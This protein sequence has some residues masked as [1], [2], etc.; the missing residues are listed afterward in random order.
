[1]QTM[2]QGTPSQQYQGRRAHS[3]NPRETLD[4]TGD[5]VGG[6]TNGGTEHRTD[7]TDQPFVT[8]AGPWAEAMWTVKNEPDMDDFNGATVTQSPL[9][10]AQ[11]LRHDH[12]R[13]PARQR[14]TLSTNGIAQYLR[15][16]PAPR[17]HR[18]HR[19]TGNEEGEV[20]NDST[21]DPNRHGGRSSGRPHP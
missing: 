6:D 10:H 11:T 8:F 16:W 14:G 9:R 1:M 2:K 3:G 21:K 12:A 20:R 5:D 17:L 18:R 13:R 15:P 7:Y 19:P 4:W